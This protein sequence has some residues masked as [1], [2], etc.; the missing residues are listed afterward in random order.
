MQVIRAP[1]EKKIDCH[2]K[3]HRV[4]VLVGDGAHGLWVVRS[5]GR[6]GLC[7]LVVCTGRDDQARFSKY[8]VG[9][10]LLESSADETGFISSL[11]VLARKYGVGSI[12]T[13]SEPN[14]LKL[15]EHRNLF[16]P[17]IHIFSPP[18]NAYKKVINKDYMRDLC[19]KIGV[20]IAEGYVLSE[21]L[22]C[23]DHSL[24][25]PRVL[26][27][28]QLTGERNDRRAPWK[29]AYASSEQEF[30]ILVDEVSDVADNILVEES[31]TGLQ[32]SINVL[33]HKGEIFAV[34]SYLGEHYFPIAGGL[35]VQRITCEPG[36]PLEYASKLM[37]E[38]GFEGNAS[39]CFLVSDNC[40]Q[41]I[42]TEINPRFVGSLPLLVQAGFELPY[43][44]W[45]S[46]FQPEEMR[47]PNYRL[48]VRGRN[49]K[50]EV[51]RLRSIMRGD[52]PAPGHEAPERWRGIGSFLLKSFTGTYDD[53]FSWSDPLP[54]I[55]ERFHVLTDSVSRRINKRLYV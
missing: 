12:M 41:F 15:I 48:G 4:L 40:E 46:H 11:N 33:V 51:A 39:I 35:T 13:I 37:T 5:L 24:K 50:G 53:T 22:D 23:P 9:V 21:F 36:A 26:R 32:L 54:Y 14:H 19:R 47:E 29:A 52:N 7:V 38:L 55:M 34:G 28:R 1:N 43:L 8:G 6:K 2:S 10:W 49:F 27:S 16:E 42:F 30:K 31:F 18:G 25:F 44:L 3:S 45:Q 20:P 17:E